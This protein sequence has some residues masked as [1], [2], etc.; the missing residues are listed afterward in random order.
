MGKCLYCM[1]K[2][3]LFRKKHNGCEETF[4]EGSSKITSILIN[5]IIYGTSYDTL[6]NR[7]KEI[8]YNA[9]INNDQLKKIYIGCYEKAV[10]AFMNDNRLSVDEEINLLTF[11]KFFGLSCDDL[12]AHGSFETVRKAGILR[13][14]W[15]G[16]MT[17]D[18]KAY[19]ETIYFNFLRDEKII[20]FKNN[21]KY[22]EQRV[23]THYEGGSMGVSIRVARGLY[24]RDNSFKGY[25]VKTTVMTYLDTGV[26]LITNK[27]IYFGSNTKNFRIKLENIVAVK[28][29]SDGIGLQKDG[30]NSKPLLFVNLD[31]VFVFHVINYLNSFLH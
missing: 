9:Y 7:I 26:F 30:V 13:D 15:E 23:K 18:M 22:N 21:V 12:D 19:N 3:G 14:L 6:L 27:H 5:A 2:T 31:G 10:S 29:Y 20:W 28:P 1:E 25:P 8:S 17:S 4:K 24:I 11:Q 16:R